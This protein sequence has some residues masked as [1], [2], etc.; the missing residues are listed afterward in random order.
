MEVWEEWG[1]EGEEL[2]EMNLCRMSKKAVFEADIY[3]LQG[4]LRNKDDEG[5]NGGEPTLE[6]PETKVPSTWEKK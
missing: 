4:R 1:V 3:T 2:K 5:W 6:W